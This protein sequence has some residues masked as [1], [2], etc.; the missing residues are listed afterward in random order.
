DFVTEKN[1]TL[2]VLQ[3]INHV[4]FFNIEYPEMEY[5]DERVDPNMNSDKKSQSDS[6]HSSVPGGDVNTAD[7]PNISGNDADSSED[8]FA[9]QDEQVTTLEDNIFSEGDLDQNPSTSTQGEM[10]DC[11]KKQGK[12]DFKCKF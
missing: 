2:N 7:F 9:A 6:S 12:K 3:D 11:D 8:I 1:D 5:D 10:Q 4:N